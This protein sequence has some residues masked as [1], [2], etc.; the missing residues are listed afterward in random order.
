M[1]PSQTVINKDYVRVQ[2][3]ILPKQVDDFFYIPHIDE[4]AFYMHVN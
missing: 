4:V 2:M 1:N 3:H